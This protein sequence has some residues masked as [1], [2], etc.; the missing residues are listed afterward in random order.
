MFHSLIAV[1][2]KLV[3]ASA[4]PLDKKKLYELLPRVKCPCTADDGLKF[5]PMYSGA[6]PALILKT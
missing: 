6:V 5:C 1:K 4:T 3:G 2:E